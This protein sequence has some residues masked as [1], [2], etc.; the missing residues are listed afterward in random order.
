MKFTHLHVH[1]HYS[2][3]DGMIQIDPLIERV[4]KLGM[5][6]VAITDH[7]TM[8]G[9]VEFYKKATAA[10]IKPIIGMEA[11]VAKR[12]LTDKDPKIDNYRYHLLLLAK[13]QEGYK[14]L[15]KLNST[16]HLE[17]FYYKPRIDKDI[18][19]KYSA[20]LIGT[21]ACVQGEV[22]RAVLD[23]DMTKAEALALEY[24][25][26][27]GK[28]NFFLE[29]E[30]HPHYK[31]QIIVNKTLYE[32]SKKLNI[33]VVATNDAH[34]LTK[35]DSEAQDVLLCIQT[36]R[37]V[38]EKNRMNMTAFDISIKSPEQMIKEMKDYPEAIDNTELIVSM[39]DFQM[40]IGKRYFPNYEIPAG[41]TV[42][43]FLRKNAFEGLLKKH[44]LWPENSPSDIETIAKEKIDPVEIERINYEL[45]IISQKEYSA[46][47]LIVADFAAWL[48]TQG[49][50]STTRGSAAGSYVSHCLGIIPVNPLTYKLPFERFL[51]PFRPSPPDID[52][53]IAD[54]KRD[55]LIDYITKK[56]GQNKVAQ[57]ITFGTMAARASVR[58]VARALDVPYSKADSI[59][60]M[61]PMGSQG[62]TMT[63]KQAKEI[64]PELAAAY[65]NDPEVRKILDLAE[66]LEGVARH[67][68]VHAA[69]LV[70]SPTEITDYLPL[71]H[72]PNGE[73]IITQYEMGA[74][75]DVGLIKFDLLGIRNLSILGNAIKIVKRTK[76]AEIILD[77]IPM[78]DKK[79]FELLTKGRTMGVFQL[80]GDGMTK[81]LKD[82][83]PSNIFDIMA[84]VALYRPGPMIS[85]PEF[86]ARKHDPTLI[87]VLDP[88]MR[89]ILEMS[90]GIITYQDDVLLIAINIAGYN[91]EEADKLRKAMGKKIV[92]E[93][94]RQKI[95][96]INGA[97]A[98]GMTPQ[99]AKDL[100]A[101]IEPFA[102][103]GFN[104][105]HAASYA[106]IAYYT[107]YMKAH[108]PAEFMAALM[109]AESGDNEKIAEAVEECEAMKIKVLPPDINESLKNFTF[110]DDK[111][112]RFGLLAIKNIG[113]KF[114]EN[115]VAERKANGNFKSFENILERLDPHELNK[116]SIEAL[117]KTGAF[118]KFSVRHAIVENIEKILEYSHELH[119][120]KNNKQA[121]LFGD[122]V[123]SMNHL[124]LPSREL[125][126]DDKTQYLKW[127]KEL[128][129]LYVS[130]H[131]LS[132][133]SR[134]FKKIGA[135][136]KD[137]LHRNEGSIIKIGVIINN[138]KKIMTKTN[139][140]MV[141]AE[142]EDLTGKTE[143]VVFA[144]VLDKNPAVWVENNIIIIKGKVNFRDQELKILVEEAAAIDEEKLKLNSN[145]DSDN[146]N[147]TDNY[148]SDRDKIYGTLRAEQVSEPI[149]IYNTASASKIII[150][151]GAD[152][153]KEK[154]TELKNIITATEK[155]ANQIILNIESAAGIKTIKT[156]YAVNYSTELQKI[157]EKMVGKEN[158][159]IE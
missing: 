87:K 111:T 14:N 88:R 143:A 44:N 91:W 124:A 84:M 39:C 58:D 99:K 9:A 146:N 114:V 69:G 127:E 77:K 150:K 73:K 133:Y 103:Y 109:T 118:D 151:I 85:I 120:N 107:A 26:I 158:I 90:Y 79:T 93:M 105:A 76:N 83:K 19:R 94:A 147:S 134:Y 108:F 82:L 106:H 68:S 67:A 55:V 37:K 130:G 35:E 31:E 61:I 136:I 65:K 154:M 5:H 112:I 121:S 153:S 3:L 81:H 12:K 40:E 139:R 49:I 159:K 56:Y 102:A 41:Y 74:V 29:L 32:L 24:Q 50:V 149:T 23:R 63:L 47:F 89:S 6:S 17:G 53:D 51:N 45:E 22:A 70:I 62:A 72:D 156:P 16:A 140:M 96:F 13:N 100:F 123:F 36:N 48:K 54:D 27:F 30:T 34:Y 129:G 148:T 7:G 135:P 157:L 25:E 138:V 10:G 145:D 2:L 126:A 42:D 18:L 115:L 122:E 142:V 1:S 33:P 92:E 15:I 57:I 86:I 117:A 125:T 152:W 144:K 95:K 60:K 104:K 101:L 131:P 43:Q 46:Y 8:Y 97:I 71:Q 59:A 113:E 52:T 110:I 128:M 80:S 28:G 66:R 98:G 119:K 116:K 21:S 78:D 11:Y 155:G 4:K 141:F 132:R 38:N 75:E 64:T 20:G 137:L